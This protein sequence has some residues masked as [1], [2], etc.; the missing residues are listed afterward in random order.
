MNTVLISILAICLFASTSNGRWTRPRYLHTI[1]E[2]DIFN[3]Q[4]FDSF[5]VKSKGQPN[6]RWFPIKEYRAGLMEV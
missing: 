5:R 4:P 6:K 3:E 1:E 2:D